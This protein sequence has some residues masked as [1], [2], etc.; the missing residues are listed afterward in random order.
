VWNLSYTVVP[1]LV[2]CL[3][4]SFYFC[5]R[6]LGILPSFILKTCRY[7]LIVI[8]CI[9]SSTISKN[10]NSFLERTHH[11]AQLTLCYWPKVMTLRTT[12]K[13]QNRPR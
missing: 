3:A 13:W 4:F 5:V 1:I 7:Y 9:C 11:L 8:N 2:C 12:K 10:C 6:N